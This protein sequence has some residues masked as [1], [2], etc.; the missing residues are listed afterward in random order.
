MADL[1]PATAAG[2]LLDFLTDAATLASRFAV[3]SAPAVADPAAPQAGS[4][5]TTT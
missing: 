3:T 1:D 4:S 2:R 5:T